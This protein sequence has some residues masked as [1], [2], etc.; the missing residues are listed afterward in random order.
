M[1]QVPVRQCCRESHPAVLVM[2]GSPPADGAVALAGLRILSLTSL[3]NLC[4][5][6]EPIG[7]A[8]RLA[9]RP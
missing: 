9:L 3:H 2:P 4:R 7:W 6:D 8:E 1:C 5:V